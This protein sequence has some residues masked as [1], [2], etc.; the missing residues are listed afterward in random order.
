MEEDPDCWSVVE[1]LAWIKWRSLEA[2]ELF[3]DAEGP[4]NWNASLIYPRGPIRPGGKAAEDFTI[5]NKRPNTALLGALRRGRIIGF[6]L[7][8]G[9]LEPFDPAFWM[10]GQLGPKGAFNLSS[11]FPLTPVFFRR[12][13]L[14]KRWDAMSKFQAHNADTD[15]G[16][17]LFLENI[18]SSRRRGKGDSRSSLRAQ[19]DRG[20]GER[21]FNRIYQEV[22]ARFENGWDK[23]GPGKKPG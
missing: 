14:Q 13:E 19:F 6:R 5:R 7:I 23:S 2:V 21:K 10:K 20:V 1:A 8:G 15:Q 4:T 17:R 11:G 16:L 3:G 9:E 12:A 22:A 18:M